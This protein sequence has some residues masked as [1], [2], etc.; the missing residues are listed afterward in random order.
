M[1]RREVPGKL[2]EEVEIE[3]NRDRPL[4]LLFDP[5]QALDERIAAEQFA[6]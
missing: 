4:T 5:E 2:V 3:L 1:I 6:T